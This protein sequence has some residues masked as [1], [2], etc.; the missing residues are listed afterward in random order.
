MP[1]QDPLADAIA[2]AAADVPARG[3]RK[4]RPVS[5]RGRP[6]FDTSVADQ[7]LYGASELADLTGY[8]RTTIY[9]WREQGLPLS[10]DGKVSLPT[11]IRF[12]E[13]R[14]RAEGRQEADPDDIEFHEKIRGMRAKND[15][16][17]DERDKLRDKL[18]ERELA[19]AIY[20]D[21]ATFVR[22]RLQGM[23]GR[24]R[25]ALALQDDPDKVHKIIVHDV[26]ET[27]VNFRE[28]RVD[29]LAEDRHPYLG[30]DDL[31]FDPQ[32]TSAGEDG[33]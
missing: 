23:A 29:P 32:A 8:D 19:R 30:G 1:R 12:L 33:S 31:V 16:V 27:L 15:I 28:D 13:A 24:L 26:E 9:K 3:P 5:K 7:R 2:A 11:V 4:V 10:E 14:A 18:I 21:D 20:K 22:V 17:E 6:T 25:T